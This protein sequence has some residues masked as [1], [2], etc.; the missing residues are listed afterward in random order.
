M[1][2]SEQHDRVALVSADDQAITGGIV[3]RN[4]M[5]INFV[6]RQAVLEEAQEVLSRVAQSTECTAMVQRVCDH[7]AQIIASQM[8]ITDLQSQHFL[9]PDCDHS[10]FEQQLETLRQGLEDCRR[11][12]R[13]VGTDENPRQDLDH[14][15]QDAIQWGEEV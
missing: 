15:T 4:L 8:Q 1:S 14:M 2:G 7:P 9:P 10:T 3:N 6:E 12:P 11:T 5:E 13:T